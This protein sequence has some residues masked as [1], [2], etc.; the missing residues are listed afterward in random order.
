MHV[1]WIIDIIYDIMLSTKTRE[2]NNKTNIW[3]SEEVPY[4][5]V[6]INVPKKPM[7]HISTPP[8]I[9]RTFISLCLRT[10]NQTKAW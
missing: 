7:L 3:F 9:I 5:L 1:A 2:I 8:I 10:R 6:Y 4:I